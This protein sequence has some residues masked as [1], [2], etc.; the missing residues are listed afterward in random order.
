MTTI[1]GN[2]PTF[3][4]I[5][6]T[7]LYAR[8]TGSLSFGFHW[9]WLWFFG[10]HDTRSWCGSCRERRHPSLYLRLCHLF[11]KYL[12]A[13]ETDQWLA[14][15]ERP[16]SIP[17]A[18]RTPP[19]LPE[20]TPQQLEDIAEYQRTGLNPAFKRVVEAINP[21]A[22]ASITGAQV[23]FTSWTAERPYMVG[24]LAGIAKEHVGYTMTRGRYAK[25]KTAA[26]ARSAKSRFLK[27][28]GIKP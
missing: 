27:E 10:G 28:R 6:L 23:M 20:K 2:M 18:W 24:V 14:E 13:Q 15:R 26:S 1:H 21:A 8:S 22:F 9:L 16:A 11:N 19:S 12:I 4:E 25:Y 7:I 5:M 17:R 3:K